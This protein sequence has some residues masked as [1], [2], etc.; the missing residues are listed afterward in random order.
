ML[1]KDNY[2][3]VTSGL[4]ELDDDDDDFEAAAAIPR[5]AEQDKPATLGKKV[6]EKT[7]NILGVNKV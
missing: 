7:K 3:L 5:K 1:L 2:S 6:M 4:L